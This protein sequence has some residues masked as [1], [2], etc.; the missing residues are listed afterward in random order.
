[1]EK[2]KNSLFSVADIV[3]RA[4]RVLN[5]K[6]DADLAA[7]LGVSRST[8]SNWIARN[9]T[10]FPLLLSKMKDVD[11]NWLLL[12]KGSPVHQAKLC[13]SEYARG[14]VEIIH[15][16]KTP[17]PV[18]DR[19]VALYDITA[20]ANLKTLLANKRQYIVGKI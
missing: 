17:D 9:S 19:S 7:Y 5:F 3:K 15:N 14:E 11:Y 10:D 12:G 8:L 4:K 13:N 16:P 20:A 18:G 6:T 2:E 1:M